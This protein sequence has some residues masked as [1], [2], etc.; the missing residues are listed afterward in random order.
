[1]SYRE[2]HAKWNQ[3]ERIIITTGASIKYYQ[4]ET[5]GSK[6]Y[7][8]NQR[9]LLADSDRHHTGQDG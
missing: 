8:L 2:E 7:L 6:Y 1:M 3:L 9:I 4:R 5:S